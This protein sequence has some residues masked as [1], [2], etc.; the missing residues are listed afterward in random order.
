MLFSLHFSAIS[1]LIHDCW[2][3]VNKQCSGNI[4]TYKWEKLEKL[5]KE[6][7]YYREKTL[8]RKVCSHKLLCFL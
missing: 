2:F 6:I 5:E 7:I 8:W 3:K 4:F 1:N